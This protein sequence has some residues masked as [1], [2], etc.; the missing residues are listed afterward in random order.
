MFAAPFDLDALE[1]TGST[2]PVLEGVKAAGSGAAQFDFSRTG[3][4][5][6]LTGSLQ[7]RYPIVWVNRQGNTTPLWEEE[8]EY[9]TPRFSPDGSLLAVDAEGTAGRD[10]WVYDLNRGVPT[11]LTFGEGND[12]TPVWSPDGEYIFFS[13]TGS[14]GVPNLYRKRA[15]GSGEEERLTDSNNIQYPSSISP[16]G[17]FL[18]YHEVNAESDWDLWLLP[19]E[20]NQEPELFLRTPFGELEAE[21]SP[22]GRWIAYQSAESGTTEIYVRPFPPEQRQVADF[23]RRGNVSALVA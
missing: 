9:S 13:S 2:A 17:R 3:L 19:L 12:D 22:N 5:V 1:M 21:F 10:V 18:A 8:Q 20:G 14:G 7:R 15:D 23:Y 6:Y 4:V 16:D 11:R